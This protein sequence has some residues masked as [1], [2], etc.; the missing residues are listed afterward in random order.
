MFLYLPLLCSLTL[1]S[2]N[3]KRSNTRARVREARARERERE[4][5]THTAVD[6]GRTE[7]NTKREEHWWRDVAFRLFSTLLY[8]H[9]VSGSRFSETSRHL[10]K[11]MNTFSRARASPPPPLRSLRTFPHITVLNQRT[12]RGTHTGCMQQ[13]RSTERSERDRSLCV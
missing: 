3:H 11:R 6:G 13:W 7:S 9:F 8:F 10:R 2:K 4:R 1:V 5:G 12:H